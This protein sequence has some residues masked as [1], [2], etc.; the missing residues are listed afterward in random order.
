MLPGNGSVV[1]NASGTGVHET[2]G[3]CGHGGGGLTARADRWAWTVFARL[4]MTIRLA[5]AVVAKISEAARASAKAYLDI[6]PQRSRYYVLSPRAV[7]SR[8][9]STDSKASPPG[10]STVATPG[11]FGPAYFREIGDV[12][13]AA[14]G[15]P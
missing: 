12:L 8:R 14:A 5:A 15:G 7:P 1:A 2:V 3:Y 9:R 11:R 4:G 10:R 6:C 13:A